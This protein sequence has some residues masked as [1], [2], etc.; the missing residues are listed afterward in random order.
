MIIYIK[1]SRIF[2]SVSSN[3][4]E[5]KT[6]EISLWMRVM[7]SYLLKFVPLVQNMEKK[8]IYKEL[9][10]SRT[11]WLLQSCPTLCNYSP[12]GSSVHEILWARILERVAMPFSWGSS[13]SRDWSHISMSLALAGAI[14][15]TSITSEA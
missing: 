13:W 12:L 2:V 10:I 7:I 14:F 4:L 1:E 11:R 6:N 3:V 15:T 5:V 8:N 9:L